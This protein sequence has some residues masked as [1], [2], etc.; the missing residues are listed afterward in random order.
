MSLCIGLHLHKAENQSYSEALVA[1]KEKYP[2][3][4]DIQTFTHGPKGLKPVGHDPELL[5]TAQKLNVNIIVH[6]SYTCVPWHKNKHLMKHT[7]DNVIASQKYQAIGAIAHMPYLPAKEMIDG[8]EDLVQM[9]R[10]K[11]VSNKLIL[12]ISAFPFDDTKSYETAEKLNELS[13]EIRKHKFEPE[14][15]ICID[16][17]HIFA[18]GGKIR[19]YEDAKK[20]IDDLDKRL[21]SMIHLNGNSINPVI[22]RG[23]KHELP[24]SEYDLIWGGLDYAESGCRA[25]IEY[26]REYNL[27]CILEVSRNHTDLEIQTFLD[28]IT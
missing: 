7:V 5:A 19:T 8:L 9:M 6:G 18:G 3:L 16:T 2:Q 24:L 11:N 17:A 21:I 14:L 22:K 27:P 23:D 26:A 25:F 4:C 28:K 15:S 12:E 1:L 20:Y 13:E 10:A